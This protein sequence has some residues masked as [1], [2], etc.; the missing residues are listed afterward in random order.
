MVAL[1]FAST[2][3]ATQS[4]PVLRLDRSFVWSMDASW[5]G[6]WSGLEVTDNGRSLVTVSDKGRFLQARMLRDD[7]HLAGVEIRRSVPLLDP[8]NRQLKHKRSDAEGLAIGSDG[9]I[10]VSF[11]HFHRL[12]QIDPA[13]GRT[14][15]KTK[16]PRDLKVKPNGGIE[17]L[18]IGPDGTIFALAE[19]H[20]GR[21][22]RP[23]P[24]YA[25][26]NGKWLVAATIPKRGRFRPVGADFDPQGR[27][28]LLER[29]TTLLGFRSR[30]RR[31]DLSAPNLAEETLLTTFPGR[32]DNLESIS[33]WQDTAGQTRLTLMSDD[34]FLS[35]QRTEII[36]FFVT[37]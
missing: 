11:E 22:S 26:A 30:I 5:F 12:M 20:L 21:T 8:K 2:S 31:F 15:Q 28:W 10:H 19:H 13:T 3:A 7:G 4:A 29:A 27:F 14:K 37:N 36:E 35:I 23:Y 32:F 34:N 6:G 17:A 25:Y 33:V 24:L 9:I 18:A 16:L 1:V